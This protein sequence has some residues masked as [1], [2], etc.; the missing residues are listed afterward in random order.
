MNGG[1]NHM[2]D[3][4]WANLMLILFPPRCCGCGAPIPLQR[5]RNFCSLCAA[6]VV[7]ITS[8][9]CPVC[10]IGLSSDGGG[11]DRLCDG[12]L[13]CLPT[14]DSARS[15]VYY[16]DPVRT[17]LHQLKFK[18]DTRAVPGL[19]SVIC[20]GGD[21]YRREDYDLIIPV[22]LFPA[23]LKKRGLNQ[24]LVLA[25]LFFAK[26]SEKIDPTVLI[27]VENTP[28]QS[29]LNGIER[30]KNLAGTIRARPNADLVGRRICLVDD[31]LTTGTTVSE[32]SLI[33]KENG[34]KIVDV[35]TFA[36]A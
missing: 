32:C 4:I 5:N 31:I 35:L 21:W 27:K 24:A 12:C 1:R 6:R 15:L 19:R 13:R 7:F 10:G 2:L 34:V 20:E 16:R 11:Q 23:R 18:A 22:P 30:R 14:F 8:P 3:Q 28:A 25:R 36:R 26:E 9:L 29:E 17:L 33:L